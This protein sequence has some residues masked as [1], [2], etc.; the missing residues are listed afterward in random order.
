MGKVPTTNNTFGVYAPMPNGNAYKV[1]WELLLLAKDGDD[2]VK[3]D[4]RYKMGKIYHKYPRYV[5]ITNRVDSDFYNGVGNG[6]VLSPNQ[7]KG[8]IDS[9]SGDL[10]VNYRIFHEVTESAWID[11]SITKVDP[12]KR[13]NKFSP[14][15]SSDAKAV[16]DTTRENVDDAMAVGE[17]Y[18]V[19]STLMTVVEEDNGNRW[20]SGYNG[21]DKAIKLV[22]DEPGY[23]E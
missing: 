10:F 2:D 5:G 23:L 13:W 11:S 8:A 14:W 17:Q 15:G 1:N 9:P 6:V 20:I 12:K 19:G 21:F 3:R 7:V 4:S 22:A 16:A 18:M